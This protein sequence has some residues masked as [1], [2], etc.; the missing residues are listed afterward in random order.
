MIEPAEQELAERQGRLDDAEHRLGR[1][2]VQTGDLL[3][4]GRLEVTGIVF[5]GVEASGGGG[6]SAKR[7]A[8]EG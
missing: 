6:A 2:L 1:L 5:R 3:A 4:L 8:R 7:S